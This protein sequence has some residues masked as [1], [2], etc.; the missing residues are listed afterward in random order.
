MT[1]WKAA[2]QMKLDGAVAQT[3]M[4]REQRDALAAQLRKANPCRSEVP[5]VIVT[6][7]INVSPLAVMTYI[8][9]TCAGAIGGEGS[10]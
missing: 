1:G 5:V 10:D 3:D 2:L 9:Y 7:R 6:D 4:L 8:S